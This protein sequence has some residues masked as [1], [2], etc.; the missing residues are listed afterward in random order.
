MLIMTP[1]ELDFGEYIDF[2]IK[3]RFGI[4]TL[5]RLH[6]SNAFTVDQLNNL[7]KA[8]LYCQ[9]NQKIRGLILTNNGNS[10]STGMDLGALGD[11]AS[12]TSD[13]LV[14]ISTDICKILFYGKPAICAVNGRAMGEGVVFMIF[15][16]YRIALKDSYFWMPEINSAIFPGTGCITLFAKIIGVPWTKKMLIFSEKVNAEKALQIDLI[17]KIAENQ[18]N[19]LNMAMEKAKS[20][21]TK[22]QTVIQAIK[23]CAN[24]LANLPY[25][26][27]VKIENDCFELY[28]CN[29]K[30]QFIEDL[31]K[32]F[33][34]SGS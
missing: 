7:K 6:R 30:E 31:R 34:K 22:N 29:N 19:L 4:I 13:Q 10:F 9:E 24:N 27:A 28:T 17:D 25:E 14:T 15:C 2:S 3:R 8:I 18:E 20:I 23:L 32:L 11:N 33:K 5:N 21:A 12:A 1:T 16:D 26:E